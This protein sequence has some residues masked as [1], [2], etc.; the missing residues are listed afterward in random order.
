MKMK[1]TMMIREKKLWVNGRE[2]GKKR[3]DKD[4]L[5]LHAMAVISCL[6]HLLAHMLVVYLGHP[7]FGG[8]GPRVEHHKSVVRAAFRQLDSQALKFLSKEAR[9]CNG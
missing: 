9:E 7:S 4:S 2:R 3:N 1:T 5:I 8:P 6:S